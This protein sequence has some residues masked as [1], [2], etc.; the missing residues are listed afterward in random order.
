MTSTPN[1]HYLK[2]HL[3]AKN[4]THHYFDCSTT[5]E[6]ACPEKKV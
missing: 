3:I 6:Q 2:T 5:I 1:N 4:F